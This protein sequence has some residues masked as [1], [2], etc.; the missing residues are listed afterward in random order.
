MKKV[1]ATGCFSCYSEVVI[2]DPY[3]LST[4]VQKS[5]KLELTKDE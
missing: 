1:D 3:K 2:H 4:E 5:S